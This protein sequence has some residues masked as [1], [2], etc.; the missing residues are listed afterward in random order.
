MNPKAES[1]PRHNAIAKNMIER[2]IEPSNSPRIAGN[3]TKKSSGP[4]VA[5][6][7]NGRFLV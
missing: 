5:T 2:M 6:F 3:A 1:T 4:D 7:S